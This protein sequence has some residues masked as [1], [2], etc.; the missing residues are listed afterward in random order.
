[1]KA[2]KPLEPKDFPVETHDTKITKSDGEPIAD[3]EN[4][5]TAEDICD[6]LNSDHAR[7]EEDRWA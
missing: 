4:K 1:M 2:K 6:R 7:E 3:A 5:A